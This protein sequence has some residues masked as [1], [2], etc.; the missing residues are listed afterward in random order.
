M[1]TWLSI[2]AVA[3]RCEVHVCDVYRAVM[4]G[5]LPSRL[6]PAEGG[7]MTVQ[8]S[9]ADDWAASREIGRQPGV[10]RA[11][12]ALV[13]L[14]AVSALRHRPGAN[15]DTRRPPASGSAAGPRGTSSLEA[16]RWAST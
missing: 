10:P 7:V 6:P 9:D 1:T 3:R 4:D 11:R 12:L 16:P 13:S 2:V 14:S 15:T 5:D 8:I